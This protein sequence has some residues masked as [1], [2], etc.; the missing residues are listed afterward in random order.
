[1]EIKPSRSQQKRGK[2]SRHSASRTDAV[3][4][5]YLSE[6]HEKESR[7]ATVIQRA[8]K[9]WLDIGVF[10]YYKDLIT[11]RI[12]GEPYHLMRFIDPKEAGFI[13]AAAGIHIRF[14]LGGVKFPPC[15]Y[16]KIFTHRPVVDLCANS[17]K[18]YAKLAAK[19][20]QRRSFQEASFDD[21]RD[22]YQRIEN[23]G[24][25]LLSN[26][27]WKGMDPFTAKDNIRIKEFHY[28]KVQK[29]QAVER[30]RKRRKI[31]WL[32]KMYFGESLQTKTEDTNATVLI[33]RAAEGL[34]NTLKDEGI[35]NVME[36]EV[37][38]LLKWTNALNYEEYV[39]E[40]KE[41]GTSRISS[42]IQGF[43]FT[44][45]PI[46]SLESNEIPN[47]IKQLVE[48]QMHSDKKSQRKVNTSYSSVA[49][50]T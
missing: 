24:W 40:W 45:K 31:E 37:D 16:Y 11:F 4:E 2:H 33:Q 22:W 50:L 30:K 3:I 34:I 35:D 46:I 1:M 29:K 42:C 14:R 17:P 28:C 13:D 48:S 5:L 49:K 8:W 27:F 12:C 43:Q 25:R 7:A 6:E 44:D 15:V 41:I 38:E 19:S 18:D 39:K 20:R 9:R 26:R 23:N 10:D 47:T 32:K 36:W 21:H